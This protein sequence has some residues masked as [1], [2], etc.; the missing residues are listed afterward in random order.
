M[1]DLILKTDELKTIYNEIQSLSLLADEREI[2]CSDIDPEVL[3]F[4]DYSERFEIFLDLLEDLKNGTL[5]NVSDI[6]LAGLSGIDD[7]S[8]LEFDP[9]DPVDADFLS[10]YADDFKDYFNE[11]LL[12]FKNCLGE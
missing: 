7:E 8:D 4:Q 2:D 1:E 9:D 5:K 12:A 10:D 11:S 3:T 6:D